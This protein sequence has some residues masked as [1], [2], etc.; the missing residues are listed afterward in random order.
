MNVK[1]KIDY[2]LR[3]S[4]L[5]IVLVVTTAAPVV[6]Y[7]YSIVTA[8]MNPYRIGYEGYVM[9]MSS[10]WSAMFSPLIEPPY[11][12]T[13]YPPIYMI[14]VGT[15]DLLFEDIVFSS[16]I[17][18]ILSGIVAATTVWKIVDVYSDKANRWIP[19]VVSLLFLTHPYIIRRSVIA[20][21]D[22]LATAFI[23]IA[24]YIYLSREG[25]IQLFGVGIFIILA[26]FTKQNFV[27]LPIALFLGYIFDYDWKRSIGW[28]T[29]VIVV[30]LSILFILDFG[31]QGRAFEQLVLVNSSLE[32]SVS[33]F[34]MRTLDGFKIHIILLSLALVSVLKEYDRIPNV[35]II[36]A[37]SSFI[38]L[39]F[40]GKS[41]SSDNMF[42]EQILILSIVSGIFLSDVIPS[43]SDFLSRRKKSTLQII[44]VIL[45]ISQLGLYIQGPTTFRQGAPEAENA[46]QDVEG[47]ILSEDMVLSVKHDSDSIYQSFIYAQLVEVGYLDEPPLTNEIRDRE[48]ERVILYSNICSSGS[49]SLQ[50]R[51]TSDQVDAIRNN[52]QLVEVAGNYWIYE[53]KSGEQ[54]SETCVSSSESS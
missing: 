35:I 3:T 20:R 26:L 52:Y 10:D 13:I 23:G 36:Y 8:L 33:S 34:L 37:V 38:P 30:G 22:M 48:Y 47:P 40:L 11:V 9:Y 6:L 27:A 21:P 14:V 32:Y 39:I 46:I 49:Y 4:L 17:V 19:V 24:L 31:T 18:S 2:D 7:L 53:P 5:I 45:I 16:R 28:T 54:N 41:G 15:V 43:L 42:L 29:S 44:L 25:Y 51:W 12:V 1:D 50:N